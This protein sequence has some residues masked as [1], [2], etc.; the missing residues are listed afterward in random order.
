MFNK[1]IIVIL[2]LILLTQICSAKVSLNASNI[3]QHCYSANCHEQA[4]VYLA[5]QYSF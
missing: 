3:A 2:L 1:S 4:L 5:K